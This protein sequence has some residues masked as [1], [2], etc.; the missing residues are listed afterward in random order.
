MISIRWAVI[1]IRY[2][3]A[4]CG[5]VRAR[6]SRLRHVITGAKPRSNL[7]LHNLNHLPVA[8]WTEGVSNV[9]EGSETATMVRPRYGLLP[10]Q[11][12]LRLSGTMLISL[13]AGRRLFPNATVFSCVSWLSFFRHD[14]QCNGGKLA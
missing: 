9:K 2:F 5:L 14:Y 12:T 3:G 7:L 1:A 10:F 4:K 13:A 11:S 8:E 6:T